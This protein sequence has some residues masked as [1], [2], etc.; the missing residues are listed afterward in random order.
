MCLNKRLRSH[1]NTAR[2][3]NN[4]CLHK[5]KFN[6]VRLITVSSIILSDSEKTTGKTNA[7]KTTV[8]T[9][10]FFQK[11]VSYSMLLGFLHILLGLDQEVEF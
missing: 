11:W 7:E 3:N 2:L 8:S 4:I 1:S 10:F 5:H 6:N 9:Y